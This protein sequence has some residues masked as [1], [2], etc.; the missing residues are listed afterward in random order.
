MKPTQEFVE[1]DMP[2]ETPAARSRQMMRDGYEVEASPCTYE[3]MYES[4][5]KNTPHGFLT[6]P[7]YSVER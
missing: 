7:R 6:R 2:A 1:D 4:P 3:S 5:Y